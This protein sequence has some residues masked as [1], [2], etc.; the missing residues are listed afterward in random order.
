MV[1]HVIEWRMAVH[2]ADRRLNLAEAD[3]C[4]VPGHAA[5]T[6]VNG[7]PESPTFVFVADETPLHRKLGVYETRPR[8]QQGAPK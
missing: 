6:L 2:V 1:L 8:P 3:T 4:C 5:V 7:D